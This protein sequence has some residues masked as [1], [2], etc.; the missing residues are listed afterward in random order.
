MAETVTVRV[1]PGSKKGPLVEIDPAGEMTIYVRERAV[2]GKA[3]AAVIRVLA[4]YLDMPR[5]RIE[6][7]SGATGR[8]K[9]FRID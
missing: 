8:L 3:N 4:E 9:R 7:V 5:S 6:L 2:D 1:K